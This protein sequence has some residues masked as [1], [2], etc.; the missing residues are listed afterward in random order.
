MCRRHEVEVRRVSGKG[1]SEGDG[2]V[3]AFGDGRA[4]GLAVGRKEG[5]EE[6]RKESREQQRKMLMRQTALKFD[7]GT[8]SRLEAFLADVDDPERLVEIGSLLI[9]SADGEEFLS[10]SSWH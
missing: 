5:R 3:T 7:A 2:I 9:A 6:G 10:R 4:Q 1:R 8:A